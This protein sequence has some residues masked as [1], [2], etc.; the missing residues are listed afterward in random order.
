MRF[1]ILVRWHLYIESGPW[2]PCDDVIMYLQTFMHQFPTPRI[3]NLHP[4][5]VGPCLEHPLACIY[6]INLVAIES[7][8]VQDLEE[9]NNPPSRLV[10][11]L[12]WLFGGTYDPRT[13]GYAPFQSHLEQFIFR[14]SERVLQITE[15]EMST[16]RNFRHRKLSFWQSWVQP[17][18]KILNWWLFCF[19]RF[20][21]LG[22]WTCWVN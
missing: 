16:W 3:R 20:L 6:Q 17:L 8:V 22:F 18:R 5:L 15:T 19:S 1:P 9:F 2:I 7:D 14:V 21:M 4:D 13:A 12:Q 10:G 11:W